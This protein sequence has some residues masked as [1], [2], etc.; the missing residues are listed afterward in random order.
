MVGSAA[1]ARDCQRLARRRSFLAVEAKQPLVVH[2]E[3]FP[4]QED[5]Q[6]A[7]AEPAALAGQ[8]GRDWQRD[9]RP[10]VESFLREAVKRGSGK[11]RLI[12]EA[13]ASIAF[14]AGSVLDL[15]S[16]VQTHLVQKRRIGTRIW[17]A[18]DGTSGGR[19]VSAPGLEL[20]TC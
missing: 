5:Q 8:E 2:N 12:L 19:F 11:L 3:A 16:G 17:R 9:I 7:V 18:D 10:R 14:L 4:A 6:P 13:H 20:G 1:W 15:K